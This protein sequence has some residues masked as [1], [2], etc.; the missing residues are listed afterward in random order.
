MNSGIHLS[1]GVWAARLALVVFLL[2]IGGSLYEHLVID[3]VWPANPALI[4]PDRGGVDRKLFWMP[5]HGAVTLALLVALWAA[6]RQPGARAWLLAALGAYLALRVWTFAYFIP[7]AM[8]FEKAESV[9][10]EAA[11]AW[12]RWSMLRAPLLIAATYSTWRALRGL[13][14]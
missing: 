13:D 7:E 11:R 10:A 9:S 1:I 5:V 4:Q 6:W 3:R 2:Q 8:R 12:V 14:G